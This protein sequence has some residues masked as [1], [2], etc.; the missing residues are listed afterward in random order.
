[1]LIAAYMAFTEGSERVK[2]KDIEKS[3]EK[4]SLAAPNVTVLAKILSRDQRCSVKNGIV[5]PLK[6]AKHYLESSFPELTATMDDTAK[7]PAALEADLKNT[8]MIDRTYLGDLR[9]MI[10]FY[11]SLHVLE[12]SMRRLIEY[13]LRRKFG[14]DWWDKSS[15]GPHKRKHE[16][17]LEKERK[18]QWLPARSGMGPLYSLDWSDLI[19]IMRRFES[20][21]T[22]FIGEVDF[23]HRF[24]DLGL[25]R[26][27]VAHNGFIDDSRQLSRVSLALHDWQ[28]QIGETLKREGLD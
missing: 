5:R 12:N 15:N 10:S 23:L 24:A 21:F 16:D 25:L 19:S 28:K 22:P 17:R 27:V 7:L 20:D 1:M 14:E 11:A 3:F 4:A 8:P 18:R 26:H 6:D 13:A 9:N 2:L